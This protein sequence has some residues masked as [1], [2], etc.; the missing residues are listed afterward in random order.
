MTVAEINSPDLAALVPERTAMVM[1]GGVNVFET[2][3]VRR[4]GTT[5]PIEVVARSIEFRGQPA[6]LTVQRDMT[7]RL[8]A[9]EVRREQARFLQGLLDAMPMPIIAKD[10]DGRMQLA[11]AAFAAGSRHRLEEIIGQ[12]DR[13]TGRVRGGRACRSDRR[14]L[15]TGTCRGL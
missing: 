12:H 1:E 2:V 14:V 5:I 9:E 3:H 10:T 15:E 6:I 7:D 13:R 11:N 8:R 4:D